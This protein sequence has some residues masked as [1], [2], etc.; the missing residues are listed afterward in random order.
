MPRSKGCWELMDETPIR[1]LVS[2]VGGST[3]V[4]PQPSPRV[5]P[6]KEELRWLTAMTLWAPSH[7]MSAWLPPCPRGLSWGHH[8]SLSC[9][10]AQGL[11]SGSTPGRF[12]A[13]ASSSGC[14]RRSELSGALKDMPTFESLDSVDATLFGKRDFANVIKLIILT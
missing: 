9:C 4:L 2:G 8:P 6:P 1:F 7:C 3:G 13:A 11:V 5:S 12:Q 14:A 10:S